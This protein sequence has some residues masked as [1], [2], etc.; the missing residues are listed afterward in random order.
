MYSMRAYHFLKQCIYEYQFMELSFPATHTRYV[1][2][3]Q[4]VGQSNKTLEV[5]SIVVHGVQ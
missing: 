5:V 3:R 1:V 2:Q 4:C